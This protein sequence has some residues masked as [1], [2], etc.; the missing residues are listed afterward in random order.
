MR[1]KPCEPRPRLSHTWHPAAP[2]NSPQCATGPTGSWGTLGPGGGL[3]GMHLKGRRYP[4]PLFQSAQLRP[5]DGNCQ[6]Q[7]AFVT[8]SNRPQPL[9][10]PPPTACLTA[11]GATSEA[12]SLPMHPWGLFKGAAGYCDRI[13]HQLNDLCWLCMEV[14]DVIALVL[15]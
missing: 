12:P 6:L 7:M 15:R 1:K 11:P 14:C 3:S 10:Q 13:E 5:S 9:W 4:P 8:D 2:L